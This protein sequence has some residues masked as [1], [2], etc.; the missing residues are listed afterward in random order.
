VHGTTSTLNALITGDVA[1][2]GFPTTRGHADSIAI[3]NLEGRYA[4][5]G[6]DQVQDMVRTDKP[7]PLVPP[8]LIREIGE[9]G[10]NGSVIVER[11]EDGTRTAIRDLVAAVLR[12]DQPVAAA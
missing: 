11:D 12:L 7:A 3:M 5:L 4:G 2:V 1:T 8:Q 10:H 9:I 6:A